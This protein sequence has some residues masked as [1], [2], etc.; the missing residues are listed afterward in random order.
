MFSEESKL[1]IK[2]A[3]VFGEGLF[4]HWLEDVGRGGGGPHE[5]PHLPLHHCGWN[6]KW[7]R[8][9]LTVGFFMLSMRLLAAHY[10]E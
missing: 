1:E 5:L 6:Y 4:D 7:W 8:V 9:V 10:V 3:A 2:E